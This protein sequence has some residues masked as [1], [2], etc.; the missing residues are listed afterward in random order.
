MDL[1]F[2]KFLNSLFRE[3]LNTGVV[4]LF[5]ASELLEEWPLMG[6]PTIV[7][8]PAACH[9]PIL[10]SSFTRALEAQDIPSVVIPIPSV[11][12]NPGLK[13]F[14]ADVKLIR[15]TITDL[16]N[17]DRDV[18]VLMHSY[19]GLPSSAAL[20]GLGKV[21]RSQ[22]GNTTGV[23]RLIY[24][25]SHVLGEGERLPDAGNMQLLRE[26]AGE[27]LNEEVRTLLDY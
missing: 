2:T 24:V 9:P 13:D 15:D 10:Y 3:R 17:H 18:I 7:I 14:S 26:R 27:G 22:G 1:S 11:G 12:A 21:D 8:V 19:G 20:K 6:S 23:V 16:L 5:P 25:S 4:V